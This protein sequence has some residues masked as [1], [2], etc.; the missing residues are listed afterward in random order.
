MFPIVA[1]KAQPAKTIWYLATDLNTPPCICL[2]LLCTLGPWTMDH[3]F[4][5]PTAYLKKEIVVRL[6]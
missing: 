4:P 3:A 1:K 5:F 2:K 6:H